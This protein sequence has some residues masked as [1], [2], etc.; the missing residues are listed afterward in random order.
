MC[1]VTTKTFTSSSTDEYSISKTPA[2]TPLNRRPLRSMD[3]NSMLSSPQT[4][5]KVK[6]PAS[7]NILKRSHSQLEQ[8]EKHIPLPTD[9][10]Y[11]SNHHLQLHHASPTR[12]AILP[13]LPRNN[14]PFSPQ[15]F[16]HGLT[17]PPIQSFDNSYPA[18][19]LPHFEV[20]RSDQVAPRPYNCDEIREKIKHYLD[21]GEMRV[22]HFQRTLSINSNSY[23]RFMKLSGP[24][25]GID[26]QTYTQALDFFTFR[27]QARAGNVRTPLTIP[28]NPRNTP[29][30][31]WNIHGI[32][33]SITPSIPLTINASTSATASTAL[34]NKRPRTNTVTSLT[35]TNRDSPR[36]TTSTPPTAASSTSSASSLDVSDTEIPGL[37]DDAVPVYDSC[38]EI[39]TKIASHLS[40]PGVTQASFLRTLAAQ[41][42]TEER[43]F[44]SKQLNTFRGY[45][46]ADKGNTSA[47][48]YA[49]YVYF[50][51]LRIKDGGEKSAHRLEMEGV[52][53][54]GFE[55]KTP[56][57]S[58]R[59]LF[60]GPG[61]SWHVDNLGRYVFPDGRMG[62][63]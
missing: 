40:R 62:T 23:G 3:I 54:N 21:S 37:R 12:A 17:L 10:P 7:F 45:K 51:R 4:D 15:Q 48:F 5:P 9:R 50:E 18:Q 57:P 30:T 16:E 36:S 27:D 38:D 44:Q 63:W 33:P 24:E 49:S 6:P 29:Q 60:T 46:G 58:Q 55:V 32:T 31:T 52:W 47:I 1:S 19:H 11:S 8:E 2:K 61:E 25:S 43:K 34:P 28:G 22:T 41:F 53:P 26:N 56:G 14:R 20:H 35:S 42:F 13:Q 59:G 39:R